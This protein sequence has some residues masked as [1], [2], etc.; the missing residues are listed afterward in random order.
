MV[1]F[2]LPV[3]PQSE[4]AE[5]T[6]DLIQH[7]GKVVKEGLGGWEWEGVGLCLGVGEIDDVQVWEDCATDWGLEFVQVRGQ[8]SETA[9]N[10]FGEKMGIPRVTEALEA[11]DWSQTTG[12]LGSDFGDFEEPLDDE[13]DVADVKDPSGSQDPDLDP[14]SLDFGVDHEDFAGLK[15]AIWSA[16]HEE[17]DGDEDFRN[18][19]PSTKDVGRHDDKLDEAE[20]DKIEGMMR[21]LQAV[22]DLGAGLPEDQRKRMAAKAVGEVMKEL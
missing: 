4:E 7:V 17:D 18:G 13:D 19:E 10:E 20:V 6:R 22:R 8:S 1:V 2:P 12:A 16:G 3:S 5:A 15:R 14:E 21:K 9:R 11:N